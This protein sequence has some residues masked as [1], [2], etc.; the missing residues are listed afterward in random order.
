MLNSGAAFYGK[1]DSADP[2]RADPT[3]EDQESIYRGH[4]GVHGGKS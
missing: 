2:E 1:S 3:G 4:K